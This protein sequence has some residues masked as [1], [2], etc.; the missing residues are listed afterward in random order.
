MY[1][2]QSSY[3]VGVLPFAG[4]V[5]TKAATAGATKGVLAAAGGPIGLAIFGVTIGLQLLLSRRGPRQ[6]QATTNIANEAQRHMVSN[7]E[8]WRSEPVHTVELQQQ[9]LGNFEM[10]WQYLVKNCGDPAMGKPGQ[11]CIS[12]RDRG[13]QYDW[14]AEYYD[15]IAQD[16]GIVESIGGVALADLGLPAGI[17]LSDLLLPAALV[18]VAVAVSL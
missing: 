15:P 14:W 12:E 3:G 4:A 17:Q 7:L 1:V 11:N 2:D 10:A 5:A 16:S 13:G 9:A 6:K 18:G 8:A